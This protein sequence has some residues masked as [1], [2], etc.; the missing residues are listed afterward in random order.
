[1]IVPKYSFIDAFS[2]RMEVNV[3]TLRPAAMCVGAGQGLLAATVNIHRHCTVTQVNASLEALEKIYGNY[4]SVWLGLGC[5]KGNPFT[6]PGHSICPKTSS[7]DKLDK[8]C[9]Q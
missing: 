6:D 1:M 2:F 9:P 7:I 3:R 5:Q 8:D 4:S